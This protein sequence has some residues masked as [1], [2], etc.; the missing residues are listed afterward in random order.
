VSL[1][2]S[3]NQTKKYNF[4]WKGERWEREVWEYDER[5]VKKKKREKR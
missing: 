4:P 5:N 1:V 3:A 2:E